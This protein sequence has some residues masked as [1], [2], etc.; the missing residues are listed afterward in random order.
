[1]RTSNIT[2]QLVGICAALALTQALAACGGGGGGGAGGSGG[3]GADGKTPQ[4]PSSKSTSPGP[5]SKQ[6]RA[7]GIPSSHDD[8]KAYFMRVY[9]VG[10]SQAQCKCKREV[11]DR[12]NSSAFGTVLYKLKRND[13]ATVIQFGRASTGCS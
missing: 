9:C 3:A 2:R 4:A 1:M 10:D 5:S 7:A 12:T 11:M 8:Q 13:Q 6:T